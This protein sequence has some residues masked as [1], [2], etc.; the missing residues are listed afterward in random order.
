MPNCRKA[1]QKQ[2]G[3]FHASICT[4]PIVF[5]NIF[6]TKTLKKMCR[7]FVVV[8]T[9]GPPAPCLAACKF[10]AQIGIASS[11]SGKT[12]VKLPASLTLLTW[13]AALLPVSRCHSESGQTT[14][15]ASIVPV[16]L[17]A[18]KAASHSDLLSECPLFLVFFR[19]SCQP[20]RRTA[21]LIL[22][23]TEVIGDRRAVGWLSAESGVC[24]R[25]KM[26]FS[27]TAFGV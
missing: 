20:R 14:K 1:R 23:S 13:I 8:R 19:V 2:H 16:S 25:G 18:E 4:K 6:S 5:F 15:N 11:C 17:P 26:F 21:L 24:P 7:I 22:P 12:A 10:K 9:T 3:N 27:D